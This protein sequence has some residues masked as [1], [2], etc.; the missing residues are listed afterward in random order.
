MA[1]FRRQARRALWTAYHKEGRSKE[2]K[3]QADKCK[4]KYVIFQHGSRNVLKHKSQG[5]NR[6]VNQR[7]PP[8]TRESGIWEFIGCSRIFT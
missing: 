4:G 6:R 8:E 1:S 3:K 5:N 2:C 7:Q